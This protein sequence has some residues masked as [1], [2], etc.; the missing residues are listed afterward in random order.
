MPS[1]SRKRVV[2]ILV[3]LVLLVIASLCIG[4]GLFLVTPEEDHKEQSPLYA[5]GQVDGIQQKD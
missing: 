4:M 2:I 5:V 3:G 1:F